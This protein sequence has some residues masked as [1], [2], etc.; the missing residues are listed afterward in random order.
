MEKKPLSK[1]SRQKVEAFD[2]FARHWGWQQDCGVGSEV[3][4]AEKNYNETKQD[5]LDRLH[6]LEH[7]NRKLSVRLKSHIQREA[8]AY[9]DTEARL[10]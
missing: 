5:L 1:C 2:Q 3:A 6:H 10:K 7:E 4:T 8:Q 9:R